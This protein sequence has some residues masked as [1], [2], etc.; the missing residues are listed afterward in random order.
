MLMPERSPT[1]SFIEVGR[2]AGDRRGTTANWRLWESGGSVTAAI[3]LSSRT[4]STRKLSEMGV[5]AECLDFWNVWICVD[6]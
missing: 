4:G 1:S 2:L 6:Q 5:L 3:P